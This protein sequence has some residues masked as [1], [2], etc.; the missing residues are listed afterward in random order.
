MARDVCSVLVIEKRRDAIATLD[1]EKGR[2][3]LVD[4]LGGKQE[5][6]SISESGLYALIFRSRK[7]E[8]RAFSKWV[9]SEVLPSIRKRGAYIDK[10]RVDSAFLRGLCLYFKIEEQNPHMGHDFI[11]SQNSK[12]TYDNLRG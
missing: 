12:V 10:Q 8:A 9:R 5:M 6:T 7:P 4:T 3:V 2:P 11:S 1:D